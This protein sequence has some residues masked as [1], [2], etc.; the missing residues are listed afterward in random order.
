[1]PTRLPPEE[2][3]I[4]IAEACK[5]ALYAVSCTHWDSLE[6][7]YSWAFL[8]QQPSGIL[9]NGAATCAVVPHVSTVKRVKLEGILH[10]LFI[11]Q[12]VCAFHTVTTGNITVLCF[13]KGITN[14]LQWVRYR[15]VSSA[16]NDNDD[17]ITA[18]RHYLGKFAS[19]IAVSFTHYDL[20]KPSHDVAF[21][22]KS[23][24]DL[25][26]L[27]TSTKEA[28]QDLPSSREYLPPP[29]SEVTFQFNGLP[30]TARIRSTLHRALY[31]NQILA[32]ICK[33]EG[34]MELLFHQVDWGACKYAMQQTWSCKWIAYT[35]LSHK[36]LNTNVQNKKFYGKSNLCPCC[37][38]SPET[39]THVFTCPSPEVA[40][41][42][43]KKQEILWTNL[44]LINTPENVLHSIKAGIIGL[45]S[46]QSCD[47]FI[48]AFHHQTQLGWEVLLRGRISFMWRT[49][50]CSASDYDAKPNLTWAG[51]LVL[52]L[53]QYSQQLW[54]FCCRVLHGHN[55]E[56]YRQ[57][58]RENLLTQIQ[59][60]YDEH[61][62]DPFHIPS[63]WRRLFHRP[64]L[65]LALSDCDTLSC[66]L[67]TYS[68]ACQQQMLLTQHLKETS[69]HY[70]SGG[71]KPSGS[72]LVPQQLPAEPCAAQD[73][74][75]RNCMSTISESPITS[76][77]D[78]ISSFEDDESASESDEERSI[79]SFDSIYLLEAPF[80]QPSHDPS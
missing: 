70:F 18:I 46:T 44:S 63:E 78:D 36:L 64:F 29:H 65:S 47:D 25:P 33:Q 53:L 49:A 27:I 51:Q 11:L 75:T 45:A 80:G 72:F 10:I 61:N 50:F 24:Q 67:Q 56:E 6:I 73:T 4:A 76:L 55:E 71:Q 12:T 26:D 62:K 1:M 66:W 77:Q 37:S 48:P 2:E 32:T 17:I 74:P 79:V 23:I 41:F 40:G 30:L 31:E 38:L 16:L 52:F 54:I 68:E 7:A 57:K 22:T 59:M 60:A 19:G 43:N 39:L 15:G 35:K 20:S 34:W 8:S 21:A 69:K 3:L 13:S 9:L 5:T 42:C 14:L 28:M 58:H